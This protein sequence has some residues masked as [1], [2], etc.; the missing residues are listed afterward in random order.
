MSKKITYTKEE[1]DFIEKND[2]EKSIKEIADAIQKPVK[3]VQYKV[4]MLKNEDNT[5][6]D[7]DL[8]DTQKYMFEETDFDD[9]DDED[10]FFPGDKKDLKQIIKP[11]GIV[12]GFVTGFILFFKLIKKIITKITK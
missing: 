9:F 5:K 2:K 12:V 11:V 10:N 8:K 1:M 3:S 7:P 4:Q 6:E